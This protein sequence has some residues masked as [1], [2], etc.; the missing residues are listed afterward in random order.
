MMTIGEALYLA[1]RRWAEVSQAVAYEARLLLSMIMS[2]SPAWLYARL[3]HELSEDEARTFLAAVEKRAT[4]YPLAYIL[5]EWGFYQWDFLVSENVLIPR[6]ETELLV[7]KAAA[8]A[9]AQSSQGE[10][11]AIVDVGAGSGVIAIALALLLPLARVYGVDISPAALTIARQ[12]ARRL[13][14]TIEFLQSDLLDTFHEATKF[15][16]VVANLPYIDPAELATLDVARWE[17][18]LALDGGEDGLVLVERLLQ[19]AAGYLK[20]GGAIMLEIGAGQG[21]AVQ[22]IAAEIWPG[23]AI[24]LHQDLAHHDRIVTIQPAPIP[25]EK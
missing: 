19:Q 25:Q 10:G 11:L 16:L 5:G 1:R 15:D 22:N 7:E 4:G 18:S 14:A 13:E 24:G 23:A 17:P 8:W 9:R 2:Q 6:P 21:T 20:P 12:N 3:D